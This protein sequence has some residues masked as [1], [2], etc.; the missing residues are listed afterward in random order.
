MTNEK[1]LKLTL[2]LQDLEFGGTQRYAVQLLKNIDRTLFDPELWVMRCGK[3]MLFHLEGSGIP[4]TY[5]SESSWVGPKSLANL[6][7]LLITKKPDVL[8][9]L[10][11]VP[12]IWGRSIARTLGIKT[13]LSGYRSLFPK[14]HEH[15]LW[16]FS[17]KIICN[18]EALKRIMVAEHGVPSE[19]IAVIPNSV[20]LNFFE[21][22]F[23]ERN[24]K[25]VLYMGRFVEDKDPL[26]MVEAL[27]RVAE[28]NDEAQFRL[29]GNGHL[30]SEAELLIQQRGFQDRITIKPAISDV[31]TAM[32]NAAIFILPSLREASPN[33][34]IE[35]MA[36]GLPVIATRVGG[37]PEL[38]VHG[39][40]GL[41]V[42]PANPA[43]LAEAIIEL[44]KNPIGAR[45]MGRRGRE[46]VE[47][48]HTIEYMVARTQ[49]VILQTARN[50]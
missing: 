13:I 40:T 22:D 3:D 17:D 2:L 41:L 16:R 50:R 34:I 7:K 33:V 46:R 11:V 48:F 32:R 15:L 47:K 18:A 8:Y 4:V 35:A 30:R 24:D 44:L 43:E 21:P 39:Q 27:I 5:L 12:N 49:E 20:D 26:N 1:P 37:I 38:V 36:M 29:Y 42:D 25:C 45:E 19:R 31:R 10:T 6:T 14:Q 28:N 23:T 9:T